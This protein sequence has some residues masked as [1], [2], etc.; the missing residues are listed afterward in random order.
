[1]IPCCEPLKN[2][3]G[4][5]RLLLKGHLLSRQSLL[6]AKVEKCNYFRGTIAFEGR[7]LLRGELAFESVRYELRPA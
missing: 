7:L 4:G 1:M 2:F 6:T 3:F 5:E